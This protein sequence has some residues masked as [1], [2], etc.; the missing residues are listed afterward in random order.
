MKKNKAPQQ[1][2][3]KLHSEQST[4]ETTALEWSIVNWYQGV[5]V[6]VCV[7]V[8]GGGGGVRRGGGVGG[9]E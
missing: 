9:V 1:A 2:A 6:C 8:G 3:T 5:C 4:S 7:C